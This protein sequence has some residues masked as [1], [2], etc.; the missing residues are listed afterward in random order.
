MY[1]TGGRNT[2]AKGVGTPD[3]RTMLTNVKGVF[4]STVWYGG[5]VVV[6]PIVE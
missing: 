4:V 6:G 2:G 5:G 1:A 3:G